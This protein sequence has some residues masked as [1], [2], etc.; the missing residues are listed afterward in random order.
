[1]N[2]N[3]IS[4]KASA[5]LNRIKKISRVLKILLLL[6]PLLYFGCGGQFPLIKS[7]VE[8]YWTTSC[9]TYATFSEVPLVAKLIAGLGAVL[10]LAA[11]ITGYQLINL[12]EK[13]I[14]FSARNVQLLGRIGCL[15]FAYGF[16]RVFGPVLVS[17]WS[18]WIGSSRLPPHFVWFWL[19]V[20]NF[21]SSPWVIGGLFLVVVS[22]IMDEGRKIQEEQEL[23]I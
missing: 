12:Y 14:I 19:N 13:G 15:A 3:E 6:Y 9:G 22:H 23:T 11:S 20:C 16:L 18:A 8:G 10:L 1:M 7:T 2:A 21:L 5:R 4:P 17:A